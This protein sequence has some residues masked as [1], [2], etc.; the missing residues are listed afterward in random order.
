MLYNNLYSPTMDILYSK[1]SKLQNT[2]ARKWLASCCVRQ[3]EKDL[4]KILR[5]GLSGALE[6]VT[7]GGPAHH[8]APPLKFSDKSDDWYLVKITITDW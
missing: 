7:R 2:R 4:Q 6:W 8:V 5:A 3:P 1:L